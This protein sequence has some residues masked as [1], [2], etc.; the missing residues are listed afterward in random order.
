MT[1]KV[2]SVETGNVDGEQGV[3]GVN[4]DGLYLVDVCVEEGLCPVIQ[5]T[6]NISYSTS[7]LG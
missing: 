7:I 2:G 5:L 1:A 3:D 4:E 6:F